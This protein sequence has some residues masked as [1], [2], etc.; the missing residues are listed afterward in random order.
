MAALKDRLRSDLTDAMRAR[1][2]LRTGDAADGADR[3]DAPRRSRARRPASWTTTRSLKMLARE[4]KKRREASE[5]FTAAG[6]PELARAGGRRARRA[7]DLSPGPARRRR[8]RRRWS[9]LP[10]PTS[11]P[12]GQD[13]PRAIGAVMKIVQPQVTGR[14]DGGRVA[15]L[16]RAALEREPVTLTSG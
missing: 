8:A 4:A 15:Q 5:A 7:R 12:A 2:E 16:V 14:A 11:G 1:D 13:G 9:T 6:R 10:W 3:R